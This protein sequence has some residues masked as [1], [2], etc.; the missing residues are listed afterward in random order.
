M[1]RKFVN[2]QEMQAMQQVQTE[3]DSKR[4]AIA[5]AYE[6]DLLLL[7]SAWQGHQDQTG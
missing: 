6:T 2:D 4:D 1:E 7:Q 3:Y 5:E